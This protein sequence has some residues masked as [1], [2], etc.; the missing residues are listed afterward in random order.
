MADY[1]PLI[2]RAV[3]GLEK[4]TGEGRRV[5]YERA[6]TALVTQL[7]GVVPALSESDITRERLALEESI[8][9]VEAEAARQSREGPRPEQPLRRD[10]GRR[11]DA[12]AAAPKRDL[13]QPPPAPNRMPPDLPRPV[14]QSDIAQARRPARAQPGERGGYPEEGMKGFRDVVAEAENLGEATAQASRSARQ[15]YASAPPGGAEHARVEPRLEPEGLRPPPRKPPVSYEP[16]PGNAFEPTFGGSLEPAMMLEDA[17]PAQRQ[18]APRPAAIED[19]LE[20]PRPSVPAVGGGLMRMLVA[21]L[22]LVLLA[23]TLFWQRD[24]VM[25]AVR[26]VMSLSQTSAPP[27][28]SSAPRDASLSRAKIPD[29]ISPSGQNGLPEAVAQRVV[30]YEEDPTDAAGK[31]FV[32]TAVWRTETVSPGP[33]LPP[34]VVIRAN[35]DIP[36][37]GMKVSW[38]LR[39]NADKTLP[40]SHTVDIMFTLPADFP[41][42]GISTIPGLLMKQAEQTR[43]VPLAGQS[44]KV[45]TGYFLIGLSSVESDLQ[46][47]VQLLK[48]RAWFDIPIVY[49]DNRRAILAVEKGPPG[50]TAFADA[51]AAW[52]R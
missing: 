42:G 25:S 47:N 50:E 14:P 6:R 24:N 16:A 1:Y 22:V 49:N 30:L 18:R 23:G 19:D 40:A 29:R 33:G 39:R 8:R 41:H 45:T 27:A 43:G 20:P 26:G 31:Q 5:L 46:R 35:I 10:G 52:A 44:V 12:R 28:S 38:S 7:R 2:A 34:D 11:E 51:F 32:G 9:K 37:R 48:E 36:E 3:A 17:R 4:N 21:V 13:S 15:A